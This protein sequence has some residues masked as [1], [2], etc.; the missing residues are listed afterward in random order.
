VRALGIEHEQLAATRHIAHRT[1]HFLSWNTLRSMPSAGES[2]AFWERVAIGLALLFGLANIIN[3]LNKGG[4]AAVFFEGG[5]RFLHAD[6]LYEGSSA[7]AGFIGPPFQAMFFAPFAWLA[8]LQ[9]VAGKLVWHL[10]NVASLVA[11]VWLAARAWWNVRARFG[12]QSQPWF[13]HLFAP[14]F[15]VL[16]PLQTNFEHQNMNTLLLALLAGATWQLTIGSALGAGILVGGATALK[17][18]PALIL[19]YLGLRRQWRA[20]TAAITSA[21]L[22][23]VLPVFLYGV[24]GYGQ[25]IADFLRLGRSGWPV[26]GNNQSLVAAVDR[27]ISGFT[28]DGVRSAADAPVAFAIFMAAAGVLGV[29]L[30]AILVRKRFDEASVPSE[31]AAVTILAILLSPIAWDHYWTLLFP[32]FLIAYDSGSSRLLGKPGRYA[33]WIAAAMTTALSPVTLGARGFNVARAM[34]VDTIAALILYGALLAMMWKA[35]PGKVG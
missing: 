21:M 14:I 27:Y 32:A 24:D 5:R 23:T 22:L 7:A 13:P 33:F 6:P 11:G 17:V 26:R 34:S 9:P 35:R 8:D 3:A 10:V 12:L 30:V 1:E 19:V 16:L 31:L 15:A 28:Q 2:S 25:L 29:L 20:L 4:D 18:F